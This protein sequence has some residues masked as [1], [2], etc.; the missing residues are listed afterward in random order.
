VAGNL[1]DLSARMA[2]VF[3]VESGSAAAGSGAD[4]VF[5]VGRD[6]P[7]FAAHRFLLCA[8]SEPF[9]AMLSNGMAETTQRE[10]T[11]HDVAPATFRHLLAFVYVGEVALSA[12]LVMDLLSAADQFEVVA[13]RALCVE[14]IL[15]NAAR[16]F[17]ARRSGS[18]HADVVLGMPELLLLELAA[19][20]DLALSELA[21]FEALVRW[22]RDVVARRGGGDGD[23]GGGGGGGGGSGEQGSWEGGGAGA[24]GAGAGAGGAGGEGSACSLRV[25]LKE[26]MGHVRLPLISP[27][28]LHERVRPLAGV[29]FDTELLTEALFFHLEWGRRSD[30]VRMQV[31]A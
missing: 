20:E 6:G 16:L 2:S 25:V 10:V 18:S 24:A 1:R 21:L 22:G 9:R 29:A 11:L 12:A 31:L 5:R 23:G 14:Y 19:S 13:L 28:H 30:C 4:V 15:R 3:D 27:L 8:A 17:G 26:L 7:C